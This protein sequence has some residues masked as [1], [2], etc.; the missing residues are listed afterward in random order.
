LAKHQ[1]DHQSTEQ[2]STAAQFL[3]SQLAQQAKQLDAD[4]DELAGREAKLAS[5]RQQFEHSTGALAAQ[6]QEL[7]QKSATLIS[8]RK[9]LEQD[10]KQL[11]QNTQQLESAQQ[12]LKAAQQKLA[13]DRQQLQSDLQSLA[14]DRAQLQAKLQQE[15]I[16][17]EQ[18][19]HE[20]TTR[21]NQ[22]NA[23]RAQQEAS[24]DQQAKSLEARTAEVEQQRDELSRQRAQLE[25]DR[26][27]LDQQ[28]ASQ[29]GPS[30][31]P[32]PLADRVSPVTISLIPRPLP[33]EPELPAE[34]EQ[35][36]T[37]KKSSDDEVV[38]ARLRAL[39]LLKDA[40]NASEP[41]PA[42]R[43]NDSA[44]A[45]SEAK[46]TESSSATEVK[47]NPPK[48]SGNHEEDVSIDDYMA[49]L[50][51][52]MRGPGGADSPAPVARSPKPTEART[53]A[54]APTNPELPANPSVDQPKPMPKPMV[55][56]EAPRNAAPENSRHLAA[57]REIAN[58]SARSAIATHHHRARKSR[59]WT[60]L[61]VG[62]ICLVC[63]VTLIYWTPDISEPMFYVGIAGL[64]VALGCFGR[65]VF[66]AR[67]ARI[68][69][70][71]RQQQHLAT[72]HSGES[73]TAIALTTEASDAAHAEDSAVE[74]PTT[75]AGATGS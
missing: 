43:D 23:Q 66:S 14:S 44:S 73:S 15:S 24:F 16:A 25:H 28:T 12:K 48:A 30:P 1:V 20:Q 69:K 4:R 22:W 29:R 51:E 71:R 42:H 33:I 39:A 38:F 18:L 2:A 11:Q 8:Q 62:A 57:M 55:A 61:A 40:P 53:P 6:R 9:Q 47:T 59:A 49:K 72:K 26:Q 13:A 60:T 70:H 65:S 56:L 35:A 50:L 10:T 74:S 52:R 58:Q 19:H 68:W 41:A 5:E 64:I 21:E 32:T 75:E 31:T 54:A 67:V 46:T 17:L 7:D 36:A 45:A 27:A 37:E 34:P 63:G 3:Q